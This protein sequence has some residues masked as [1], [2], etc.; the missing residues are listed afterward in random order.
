MSRSALV[1][2]ASRGFGLVTARVLSSC[3]YSVTGV[4]RTTVAAG[5]APMERYLQV[6]VR[7]PSPE[8]EACAREADIL[9]N[10]AAVYLDDPR[11]GEPPLLDLDVNSLR[12]S[13]EINFIA[14]TVLAQIAM[15]GMI[16]RGFGR[17]VNISTGMAR[18]NEFD[19]EAFGYRVSKLALNALT[20]ALSRMAGSSGSDVSAF[21]YCPGWLPT[22]MGGRDATGSVQASAD[23]LVSLITQSTYD[24]NGHFFRLDRRLDWAE[25]EP[26][27]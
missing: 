22:D 1:T 24:T 13:I 11:R 20:L 6:D 14:P 8:L 21:A 3:G 27:Q 10:N 18:L 12:T 16:E 25:R 15:R 26:S 2:G 23:A 5:E 9:I 4:G 17:I 7:R 19:K